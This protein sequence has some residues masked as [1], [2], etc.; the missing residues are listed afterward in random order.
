MFKT[1]M[2]TRA[3]LPSTRRLVRSTLIAL[4][5][6]IILLVTV[7]LPSEYAIDPTG[8]GRMLGLT[9]MGEIKQQLTEEV[10]A[11]SRTGTIA[12]EPA[13]E[14]PIDEVV[15][16][17]PVPLL[18]PTAAE[19][20]D[21]SGTDLDAWSD[22]VKIV[23]APGEAAEIKLVMRA[24]GVVKFEWTAAPGHLNSAL[25]GDGTGGERATYRN[26]RAETGHTDELEAE[27]D[28]THGWFW[29]NRSKVSVT[30]TLRV[31]GEYTEVKRV[32]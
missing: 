14:V 27:F 6:A 11:D 4:V 17:E 26:G 31:R 30:M 15:S 25:H 9:E 8:V 24:G 2:P 1:D 13:P 16:A 18:A 19:G 10:E 21:L 20:S 23:L 5:T 3:E 12:L 29:R 22:E 28:G 32:L 7:V